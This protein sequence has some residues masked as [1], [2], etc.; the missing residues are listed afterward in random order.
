MTSRLKL[1]Q[2]LEKKG[3]YAGVIST[4][5]LEELGAEIRSLHAKGLVSDAIYNYSG[6][7]RPYHT[8]R[9][10]RSMPRAK[11]IIVVAVPQPIIRTTFNYEGVSVK[12]E[13]PPT[14][15]DAVRA[16]RLARRL[17]AEA[18]GTDTH[19][20][21][22]A[23]LPLKL[24]AVRSGLA[25]YGRNNI[26]YIPR[27]G[28]FHRL[29]AFYSDFESPVDGWQEK[30]ALPLC[31]KCR[32]C[33]NACPTEAIHTD[34]F[35]VQAETCLTYLNEKPSRVRFPD[36]VDAS[37]HNALIGCMRCQKACPYNK[38]VAGW[39]EDRGEFS[40]DE[41]AYLLK[42]RYSGKKAVSIERKL[43]QIG[44]DLSGF[45]RNLEVLLPRGRR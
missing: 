30:K 44:L 43:K 33:F 32:A 8:P 23:M 39:Y 5:H 6:T 7:E 22:R 1:I 12:L 41:T 36:W 14:Y 29:A 42:G 15:Y 40:E 16:T 9:L 45:P 27:Y 19:M 34:R 35:I 38:E 26:T 17:L 10:P 20:L 11:S 18:L 2:Y 24:L 13:V 4:K 25:L 31:D 28:S 37:S 21:V 3:C